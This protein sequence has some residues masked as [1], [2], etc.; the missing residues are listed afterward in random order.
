M[1]EHPV[2]Y[3]SG[4]NSI[5]RCGSTEC[6][7]KG[8]DGFLIHGLKPEGPRTVYGLF[9]DELAMGIVL[10]CRKCSSRTVT[11]SYELWKKILLWEVPGKQ[12]FRVM[13]LWVVG[14][15]AVAVC[16]QE[17]P[18]TIYE[19]KPLQGNSTMLLLKCD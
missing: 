15:H 18:I 10:K 4:N 11:T 14:V 9:E 2:L 12:K 13:I 16:L 5:F 17:M 19:R 6:E 3:Y 8:K 7:Q 1:V